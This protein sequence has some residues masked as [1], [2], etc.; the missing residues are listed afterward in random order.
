MK[1]FKPIIFLTA[2]TLL[3]THASASE[4]LSLNSI[5]RKHLEAMGG[6]RNWSQVES[7]R[8]SGTIERDGQTVDIVIIKKRPNQIRAT[9]TVPLP[10]DPENKVQIIRAHDG[11]TAWTATRLAGSPELIKKNLSGEAAE[12]L[13][14]DA[15][16]MPRLIKLWR[17]GEDLKLI[18][19]ENHQGKSA[20]IIET[21]ANTDSG[22]TRFYLSTND[23]RMIA[24]QTFKSD[25]TVTTTLS[26]YEMASGV[27]IPKFSLINATETGESRMTTDSIKIGVGIYEEYFEAGENTQTADL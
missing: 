3:L 14:S 19:T 16:V 7:I 20:Y 13:I 6:L 5:L 25:E 26:N 2:L 15:G 12:D 27:Y 10:Y 23:Y 8:M 17:A 24:H 18:G 1:L 22:K 21:Q 11:K 4:D 9:V